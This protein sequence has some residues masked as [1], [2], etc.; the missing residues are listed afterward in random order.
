[1]A[2]SSTNGKPTGQD[3]AADA[4]AASTVVAVTHESGEDVGAPGTTVDGDADADVMA[5]GATVGRYLVVERL[6]AGAMGVVYAAYD[7]KLDRKIALKLLRPRAGGDPARRTA[8]LEREAQGLAKLSH[9][10]VVGIF[11]VGVHDGQVFLA[12]EF[13]GGGT[14]RSWLETKPRRPWRD[15]L[16]VFVAVG[17]GLAAAH[18]EGLIHRDFKPDNVLLDKAGNPKVVD[19]G[20]VR[21]TGERTDGDEP[22]GHDAGPSTEAAAT[23]SAAA[24]GLTR[25]GAMTGT[26]AYMAAEQF[27]GRPIDARTDQFAFCVSLYEALLGERPFPGQ[28]ILQLADAV[29]SDRLR[30]APKDAAAPAW[31]RKVVVH[32]LGSNPDTRWPSMAALIEA[33]GNDPAVKARRRLVSGAILAI[34]AVTLLGA[35][36]MVRLRH[37]ETEGEIARNSEESG[38]QVG[39]ART[40]AAAAR[41]LRTRA[42]AAFDAMERDSGEALWRQSRALVGEIDAGYDRAA[43]YLDAAL[44]L[45]PNRVELRGQLADLHL[46]HIVF[47]EEVRLDSKAQALLPR[48]AAVDVDG[49]R[50]KSLAAEGTLEVRTRPAGG[51][52]KMVLERYERDTASGRRIAKRVADLDAPAPALPLPPGSYRL[53]FDRKDRARLIYAVE[54]HRGE[55]VSLD[56]WLPPETAVPKGF[57]YVPPGAFWFG[58][59]DE[60][61]RT[62]FLD[63]VPV[64]RRETGGYLIARQETT[65]GEW[66]VFLNALPAAE[67]ERHTP[68]IASITRG[69]LR[70]SRSGETGWRL[71]FQPTGVRHSARAGAEIVY[72]GRTQNARQDWLNFPVAGISAE[73]AERYCAWLRETGRVPGARLCSE[74]EW[75][76]AAR[77]ADDRV[78]PHGDELSADD[79][80]IDVSY[81]RVD[82]AYG[83][84]MVGLHP[85]SRSPFEVDDM[86]GNLLELVGSSQRPGEIVMRGGAYFFN[87]ITAR[88][89]NRNAV[90]KS[91]RDVTTGIR[92]CAS[93]E[94]DN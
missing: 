9:P 26:P 5:V 13:L 86:A 22:D 71:E 56:V 34:V 23:P 10:N 31:L 3:A 49:S 89:T 32:G 88:A 93:I 50:R 51:A 72:P 1:M 81:G 63:T 42:F 87:S 16:S 28:T 48:L 74:L 14:L 69:S 45:D 58:D 46:Q 44:T 21:L 20:L 78:F 11:D 7:P 91:F 36:H 82:S 53:S 60:K 25:T 65:Y 33:L 57:V 41:D 12:M 85:S 54:V 76:R 79:A 24:A 75:E 52:A 59:G 67:R 43:A 61:L 62:Q 94:G 38:R 27:L 37:G 92:V 70:L 73:E 17:R 77:G 8:R 47:A 40:K 39:I 15:I 64:H 29:T 4:A 35:R 83:P 30:D 66:I 19:F 80:N 18:A 68:R 6:G 84:D 2:E 55:R 90:S